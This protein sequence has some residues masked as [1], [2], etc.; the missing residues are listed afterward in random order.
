MTQNTSNETTQKPAWMKSIVFRRNVNNLPF[1]IR[2]DDTLFLM[3]GGGS[4]ANREVRTFTV[5]IVEAHLNVLKK[6]FVRHSLLWVALSPLGFAAGIDGDIDQHEAVRLCNEIL[7]GSESE[8]EALFKEIEWHDGYLIA[9]HADTSLLAK[10]KLFAATK[11]LTVDFDNSLS[12]A[13]HANR[14]RAR[15]G[16][17]LSILD[18]AILKYTARYIHRGGVP[19]RTPEAVDPELLPQVLEIV[20]TAEKAAA[21]MDLPEDWYDIDHSEA[22][23]AWKR[24]SEHV[25]NTLRQTYPELEHDSLESLGFLMCNDSANRLR[26]RRKSRT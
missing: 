21:G 25:E 11:T 5:P 15:R 1:V 17:F 13:H 20:A 24:M 16:V 26:A 4:D 7:L 8:V 6:D 14:E 9:H 23:L 10:G 2:K 3:F 22:K 19:K 18:A 12:E